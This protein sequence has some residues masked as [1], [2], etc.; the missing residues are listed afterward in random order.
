MT[1]TLAWK[2]LPFRSLTPD[3]LYDLLKLRQEV[4]VVEQECAYLDAD[5]ADPH[6]HHLLGYDAEGELTAY[7]RLV[8]PGIKYAEPSIG[9]VIT[10]LSARRRNL[11]RELMRE[12]IRRAHQLYP[13]Q[14]IR[15]SAQAR[16]ERFYRELGFTTVGGPY[17]EDGIPH[18]EM[19]LAP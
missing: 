11:G 8:K 14:G 10:R 13:G 6:A 15:I 1:E 9:R 5:G 19:L 4:F 18:L 3:Q 16:L 17:D 2:F 7:L 12:G